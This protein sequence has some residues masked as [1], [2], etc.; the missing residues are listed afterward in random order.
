MRLSTLRGLVQDVVV[1]GHDRGEIGLFIFPKPGQVHGD[2]T[3]EGAVIDPELQSAIENRLRAMAQAAPP[4]RRS[5][6]PVRSFWPSHR[7]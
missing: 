4:D 1:C 3:S 5:A 7:A 6:S 2:T